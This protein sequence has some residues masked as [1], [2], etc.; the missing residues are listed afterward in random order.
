MNK[1]MTSLE[2]TTSGFKNILLVDDELDILETVA[3]ALEFELS[4]ND[5]E[6]KID[7]A[8]N[9]AVALDM[10]NKGKTYDLVITDLN[11]PVMSGLELVTNLKGQGHTTPVIVF[12]G[13][14]DLEE[15]LALEKLGIVGMIK[16]P[17][18]EKLMDELLSLMKV[19][20]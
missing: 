11:M 8:I 15:S 20:T 2:V 12:T 13:H 9:G 7:T 17:F 4:E 10:L 16:K 18:I 19:S 14:G 6:V 5:I 1:E 3:D